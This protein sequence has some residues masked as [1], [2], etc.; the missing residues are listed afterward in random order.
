MVTSFLMDSP[1]QEPQSEGLRGFRR[2]W[3]GATSQTSMEASEPH[4]SASDGEWGLPSELG[5]SVAPVT[6]SFPPLTDDESGDFPPAML[7][8]DEPVK[9][10]A[11][12]QS[13][14]SWKCEALQSATKRAKLFGGKFAWEQSNFSGV[15]GKPD[16][17]AGTIASGYKSSLAP[18]SIGLY[19]V[20]QSEVVP[21]HSSSSTSVAGPPVE[22]IILKGARREA[23]EE[24]V[25][26][27]A[28]N[29]LRELIFG[30][31][32]STRL[33]CSLQSQM[34][35]DGSGFM[36]EQSLFD[37]FRAKASTTLQKRANSLWRLAKVFKSM[38]VLYPLRFNEENLY[39]ALCQL[40]E[41][42]AGPTSGQHILEALAFLD[43]TAGL[44]LVDL[45]V[46]ISGR[47]KGVARDMYLG[48]DPL[49]QKHPLTVEQ[50]RSLEHQIQD[51][52]SRDCCVIGQL[53]F[54]IH[55]VCRWKDA[56]RIKK[57]S[58]EVAKD[59]SLLQA[60][61]ISSKTSLTLDAKTRFIPYAAL[62]AGVLGSFDWAQRWLEA[63]D[64]EGL[65]ISDFV[66]PSFSQ[67]YGMWLDQPM[68]SSEATCWLREFLSRS[69]S[70]PDLSKF[71]SH[72]CKATVLT[73]VGRSTQV[74]FSMPER[75]LLGHHLD[76]SSKKRC[77]LQSGGIHE[78]LRQAA[79]NVCENQERRVSPGP[80][81]GGES[82][83]TDLCRGC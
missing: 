80:P 66:L 13:E 11:D 7:V 23:A 19:D 79:F 12:P 55:G 81:G 63:R 46:A 44:A 22:A 42:K 6:P 47:C 65:V 33:G 29:K 83:P 43:A 69:G 76:Q 57:I 61:A 25:R 45:G 64:E 16:L 10:A 21:S 56:Q 2:R 62:G 58:L 59:E 49:Q 5:D 51:A 38:G 50:V 9:V 1:E 53:L 52:S 72:S 68:S 82:A 48:N 70:A 77:H 67:K 73:W 40:R 31:P 54:C 71:G 75:R 35:S 74:V 24:D 3:A 17:F 34:K 26:R 18:T 60:D 4:L 20:L 41:S 14:Y 37:C 27:L 36:V 15:F 8:K 78:H 30:D 32:A 28:L 39:G